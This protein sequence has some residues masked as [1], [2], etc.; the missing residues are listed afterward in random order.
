M[1]VR[2]GKF[3]AASE[4]YDRLAAGL[5]EE[6][7]LSGDV[8][9]LSTFFEDQRWADMILRPRQRLLAKIIH[10]AATNLPL[11]TGLERYQFDDRT[12]C[13]GFDGDKLVTTMSHCAT[14][15]ENGEFWYDEIADWKHM[16]SRVNRYAQVFNNLEDSSSEPR[17]IVLVIGRGGGK[18]T[19]SA[20]ISA[21]QAYRVLSAPNPHALF[22]LMALKPL[23]IQN[24][25]TSVA[26]AGEFFDAFCTFIDRVKWFGGRHAPPKKGVVEF[27]KHLVAERSSSNSR[28]GRG[29]D[30]VVYVH[31]EIAF[32][33]KTAGARSD[34]AL[35][36]AIYSAVK[37]RAKGRGLVLILSS[38]AEADGV[39]YELYYQAQT[40]ELRNSL[41]IQLAS[42]EM[43]PGE[44]KADYAAEYKKDEDV[45][46]T[47][48]GAQF[49]TG[50][51]T[52]LPNVREKFAA[53]EAAYKAL[54][55]RY[56]QITLETWSDEAIARFRKKERAYDRFIHID[57]SENSDRLVAAVVHIRG[58]MV[59]VDMV[60]VW[61]REVGYTKELLPFVKAVAERVPVRQVSFD[62]FASVQLIQ[63]L[64]DLGI[65]AVKTAFTQQYNDEIAR[66]MRQL[67]IEDKLALPAIAEDP[68][69]AGALFAKADRLIQSEST[70]WDD[71]ETWPVMSQI[72]LRREMEV[73]LK[74]LSGRS[75]KGRKSRFIAAVAPTAGPV[76]TD[77]ALD[78]LM[79]A[80]HQAITHAGGAAVF[81]TIPRNFESLE[82]TDQRPQPDGPPA[83]REVYC[84]FC[85][86]H[87]EMESPD[88]IVNCPGC[89]NI[90]QTRM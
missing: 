54:T 69:E 42:W 30:T 50:A 52:L 32:A 88:R 10:N 25:A 65:D 76:Q 84:Q 57:T 90:I 16:C 19:F 43:I 1:S 74:T 22:N 61:D 81:F 68:E 15:D 41:V 62:Q 38:P 66:N 45:A 78:A 80:A 11:D 17:Q 33:D 40:G 35:Y 85:Q 31:D 29:R 28:S 58:G 47:E 77:D 23:R 27:G 48:F 9:S 26:Q 86:T 71:D 3:M 24:V 37:T 87:H 55:G 39:L 20:G 36:T 59:V 21:H 60:R 67:V 51:K 79:S 4:A 64:Q 82:K 83:K 49:F 7:D 89:G 12:R 34:R 53:M 8:V 44:T 14:K 46:E 75:A 18:T 63:D 13:M 56:T 2:A 6:A 73:A 72:V 70:D 5:E